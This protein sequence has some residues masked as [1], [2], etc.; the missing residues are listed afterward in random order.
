MLGKT[1]GRR[2]RGQERIRWLDG[3]T[4]SMD[5]NL[6]KLQEMVKD[7]V[8]WHAAGLGVTKSQM[9]LSNRTATTALRALDSS[10]LT[11]CNQDQEIAEMCLIL[12]PLSHESATGGDLIYLIYSLLWGLR[13]CRGQSR[14][15][16]SCVVFK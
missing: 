9:P 10:K 4:N 3:I 6:S 5:V 11:A 12:R 16:K 15:V 2:R 7:G 13:G 8:L 14:D 1:E